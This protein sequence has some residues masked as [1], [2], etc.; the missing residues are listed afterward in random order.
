MNKKQYIGFIIPA[1]VIFGALFFWYSLRPSIIKKD[2]YKEA[3]EKAVKMNCGGMLSDN[4]YDAYYK[5][6][7][8][9]KG[10]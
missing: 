4:D 3:V 5:M 10:L 9:K 6:C 8:Q 7:L 2:C 1:V